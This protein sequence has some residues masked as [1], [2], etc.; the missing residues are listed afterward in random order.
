MSRSKAA[1]VS[2]AEVK[3]NAGPL[4]DNDCLGG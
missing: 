1:S 2:L 4:V 3:K